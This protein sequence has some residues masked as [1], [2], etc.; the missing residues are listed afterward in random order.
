MG[1]LAEHPQ[2]YNKMNKSLKKTENNV[3]MQLL[4][5]EDFS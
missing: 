5:K 4:A 1:L 2:M 3:K